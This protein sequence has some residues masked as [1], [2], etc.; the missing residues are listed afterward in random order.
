VAAVLRVDGGSATDRN[1]QHSF[2]TSSVGDQVKQGVFKSLLRNAEGR[3]AISQSRLQ[4]QEEEMGTEGRDLPAVFNAA[5][6]MVP[7]PSM[8]SL[9]KPFIGFE[10]G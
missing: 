5:G 4:Q 7:D 9:P 2:S 3:T 8:R 6:L 10:T 1:R